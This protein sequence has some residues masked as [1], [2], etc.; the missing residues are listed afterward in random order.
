MEKM[1]A[2]KL[3]EIF[4]DFNINSYILNSMIQTINLYKKRNQLEISLFLEEKI[5][6]ADITAF[7]KYLKKRFM[8]DDVIIKLK[9]DEKINIDFKNEWQDIL[10]YLSY[11]HPLTKALLKNSQI[12]IT[13]NKININLEYFGS[14][15]LY[16]QKI[17]IMLSSIIERFFGVK[18][19][20]CYLDN[21]S[22]ETMKDVLESNKKMQD[23][24]I[25][26]FQNKVEKENNLNDNTNKKQKENEPKENKQT[27]NTIIAGNKQGED[28]KQKE[29]EESTPLILGRNANIKDPL[30]KVI[31]VSVDSG[32]ICLDGEVINTDSRELK[33]GKFLFMFDLY[34][35]TSTITCKAF[36][37]KEKFKEVSGRITGA[38]GIKIAGTAQFDPFAKEL[39]SY[40]KYYHRD[41]WTEKAGEKR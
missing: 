21:N 28:E 1:G 2:K 25:L 39:R 34:D 22:E 26:E 37:E 15:I 10:D 29:Q 24:L 33:S 13:D 4:K 27:E 20:I 7:E 16:A 3:K 30:T 35:G 23:G 41:I 18:Y 9:Y 8:L 11:K 12:D 19:K 38:K 14:D 32:K 5:K 17:D 36:I 40:C 6:I 31:D